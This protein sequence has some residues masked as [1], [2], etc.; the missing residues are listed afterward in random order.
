MVVVVIAPDRLIESS[1]PGVKFMTRGA[2]ETASR[3][4]V[5]R[6]I[7]FAALHKYVSPAV[8]AEPDQEPF[9]DQE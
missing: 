8:N 9:R 3:P 5:A 1:S 7:L 4:P 2:A 6:K